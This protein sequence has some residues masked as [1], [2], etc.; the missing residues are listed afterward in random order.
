MGQ[1]RVALSRRK[2]HSATG[3][4]WTRLDIVPGLLVRVTA[5]SHSRSTVHARSSFELFYASSLECSTRSEC[6]EQT[7]AAGDDARV[8]NS[9]LPKE[10]SGHRQ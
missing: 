5:D 2:E 9:E 7:A 8:M 6:G 1:T 3:C 10:A 4:S